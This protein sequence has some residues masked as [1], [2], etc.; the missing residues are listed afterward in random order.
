MNKKKTWKK[1]FWCKIGFHKEEMIDN[2]TGGC[3]YE[4]V[5]CG[6]IRLYRG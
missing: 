1:S 6:N 4:C 5:D 3:V 2:D